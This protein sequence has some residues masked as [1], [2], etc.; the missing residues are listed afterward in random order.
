MFALVCPLVNNQIVTVVFRC[1]LRH[2]SGLD[3]HQGTTAERDD[4][5]N[6]AYPLSEDGDMGIRE[7]FRLGRDGKIDGAGW[8]GGW[9]GGGRC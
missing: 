8:G 5:E 3:R 9:G 4:V 7:I 6:R 1:S 2:A